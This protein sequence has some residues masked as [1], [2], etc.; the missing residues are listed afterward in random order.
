MDNVKIT[1]DKTNSNKLKIATNYK[2]YVSKLKLTCS[3][4]GIVD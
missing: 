3:D 4:K 2:N 1:Y